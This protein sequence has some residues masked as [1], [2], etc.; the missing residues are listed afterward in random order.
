M[1]F[2]EDSRVKIPKDGH[3]FINIKCIN[4]GDLDVSDASRIRNELVEG[5]SHFLLQ[6]NDIVVSTSASLGRSAVVRKEHLPLLLNTSVIRFRPRKSSY[7]SYM[8]MFLKSGFFIGQLNQLATGSIQKNFGP[9]H[10]DAI[11][12]C[13]PSESIFEKFHQT[14]H[15]IIKKQILNRSEND[16]LKELR[17]WLLPML[18]NGQIKIKDAEPKLS[19]AAEPEV[20]YRK[21]S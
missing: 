8:S 21:K 17:D 18:M 15:P 9:T 6:E 7:F 19:M 4:E 13:I 20:E 14:I 1:A 11:R 16:S 2:N 12:D 5:Y 3:K 10:L